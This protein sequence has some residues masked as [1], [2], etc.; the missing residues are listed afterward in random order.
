MNRIK[1]LVAQVLALVLAMTSLAVVPV[2][3]QQQVIGPTDRTVLPI[4]QPKTE[5]I[6]EMD[7]RNAKPPAAIRSESPAGRS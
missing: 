4:P 1:K 3:A 6:T 2:A 5:T 7:A